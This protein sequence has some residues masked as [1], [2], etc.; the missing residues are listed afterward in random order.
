MEGPSEPNQTNLKKYPK[1]E[2]EKEEGK[3]DQDGFY[4]LSNGDF[5]DNHG[6]YF[7][8]DG[9]DASGGYY[10]EDGRYI[11]AYEIADE[12]QDDYYDELDVLMDEF[13]SDVSEEDDENV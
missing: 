6:Y 3:Y 10:A 5:Y 2:I 11:A 13:D 12:E 1:E 7:D 9:F 4:I 8:V